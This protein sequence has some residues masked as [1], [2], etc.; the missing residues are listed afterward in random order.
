MATGRDFAADK[1]VCEAATPAPWEAREMM[2][3]GESGTG[4]GCVV[5]PP[6]P[7]DSGRYTAYDTDRHCSVVPDIFWEDARFIA[8]AREG[9]PAALDEI[10]R[11]RAALQGIIDK[12]VYAETGEDEWVIDMAREALGQGGGEQ[13]P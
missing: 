10:E 13:H 2:H 8:A 1:A 4:Y 7:A 3:Y 9:W 5:G 6:R 11:L 12:A